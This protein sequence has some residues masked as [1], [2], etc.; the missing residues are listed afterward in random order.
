MS[1]RTWRAYDL[2]HPDPVAEGLTH[3]E[4]LRFKALGFWV[5]P[6]FATGGFDMD[7]EDRTN[8]RA[9][10]MYERRVRLNQRSGRTRAA[11]QKRRKEVARA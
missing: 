6:E 10:R 5:E 1:A 3:D 11:R 8:L 9:R 7:D 2:P 4:M